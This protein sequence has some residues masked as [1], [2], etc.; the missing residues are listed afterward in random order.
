M[1]LYKHEAEIQL[2]AS[3]EQLEKKMEDRFRRTDILL[4]TRQLLQ[5]EIDWDRGLLIIAEGITKLGFKGCA[6]FLV[7]PAR[8]TLEYH[9]GWGGVYL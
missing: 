2:K 5:R 6:V 8:N 9:I 1:A 7:N 3:K 4:E